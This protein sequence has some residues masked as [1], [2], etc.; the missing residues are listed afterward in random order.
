MSVY[1]NSIDC[2]CAANQALTAEVT[3]WV[4][5]C[6]VCELDLPGYTDMHEAAYLAAV[7]DHLHHGG[8]REAFTVPLTDPT[9]QLGTD[10][11]SGGA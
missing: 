8:R 5:V 9:S 2:W 10:P 7:H 6:L 4:I 1:L 11:A 3:E